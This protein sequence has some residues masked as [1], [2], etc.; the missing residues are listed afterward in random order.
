MKTVLFVCVHNSGRSQ[1]AEAIFNSLAGD[2]ARAISAGTQPTDRVNPVVVEAMQK[3]GFDIRRNLPR[4][5]TP[6]ML[7][8]AD[9][10]ISMGCLDEGSCPARL[11]PTEDWGLPDPHGLG[12]AEVIKIRDIVKERVI[13]LLKNL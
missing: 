7:R 9:R 4:L 6:E 3:V 2:K 8:Q 10:V 12:I 11:V 1:M 5:L 13:L